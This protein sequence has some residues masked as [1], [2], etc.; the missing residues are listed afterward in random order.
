M[1][2]C[3]LLLLFFILPLL[4]FAQQPQDSAFFVKNAN[5]LLQLLPDEFLPPFPDVRDTFLHHCD[6]RRGIHEQTITHYLVTDRGTKKD[7][8]LLSTGVY[9]YDDE[10]RLDGF[11]IFNPGDHESSLHFDA[12][13]LTGIRPSVFILKRKGKTVSLDTVKYSYNNSGLVS[14]VTWRHISQKQDTTYTQHWLY[15]G[16]HQLVVLENGHYGNRTG[17]FTYAYNERGDVVQRNFLLRENGAVLATDT[18]IYTWADSLKQQLRVQHKLRFIGHS[19]WLLLEELQAFYTNSKLT[20]YRSP[21]SLGKDIGIMLEPGEELKL[22]YT[23][24]G[25]RV[26]E[27]YTAFEGNRVRRVNYYY[28]AAQ[29]CDSVNY[30]LL[31]NTE[32]HPQTRKTAYTLNFYDSKEHLPLKR[33]TF[34]VPIVSRRKKTTPPSVDVWLY[35]WD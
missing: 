24:K 15:D 28:D 12:R 26:L 31:D 14:S 23:P 20:Y 21:F 16:K 25:K 29:L 2:R 19:D 30:Y 4:S 10:A 9:H 7:S 27:T 3:K 18:L 5:C 17:T 6:A 8:L 34:T 32:K 13:Y 22:E 33:E 35:K 11:D 1:W